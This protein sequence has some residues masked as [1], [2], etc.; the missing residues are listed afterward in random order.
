MHSLCCLEQV[1]FPPW[2]SNT[3]SLPQIGGSGEHN[4]T[5]LAFKSHL[6]QMSGMGLGW[7]GFTITV[8][9]F[10]R[11]KMGII[12]PSPSWGIQQSST[13]TK[14]LTYSRASVKGRYLYPRQ[15]QCCPSC[16]PHACAGKWCMRL[17]GFAR[18][19]ATQRL[20]PHPKMPAQAPP[21]I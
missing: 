7:Y 3:Q 14:C 4:L 15:P 17:V 8:L 16:P 1:T 12:I 20:S 6:H 10:P 9:S 11:S 5:M 2:G 21:L 19:T 18:L 13:H